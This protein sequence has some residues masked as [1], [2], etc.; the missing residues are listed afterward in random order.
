V[1][2]EQL[3]RPGE[4]EVTGSVCVLSFGSNL[5]DRRSHLTYGVSRLAESAR[6]RLESCS[7]VVESEPWGPVPQGP[8]LN[9]LVR[10]R[11]T[12]G[13]FDLL[14]LL[15][16]VER[17]AGRERNLRYGPRTLDIDIIFFGGLVLDSSALTLPHP[18]WRERPFV[19]DLLGDVVTAELSEILPLPGVEEALQM[20]GRLSP[21]LHEVDSLSL[22]SIG[23]WT[24][25][26]L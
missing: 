4:A 6:F 23:P 22:T 21:E 7:R 3:N 12:G 10:G 13:P 20:G 18:F 25:E 5:G 15:Q 2:A 26:A 14:D 11:S 24:K 9:L 19:R 16:G 17:D 8:Y 1:I